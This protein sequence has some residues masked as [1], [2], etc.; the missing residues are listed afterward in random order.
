MPSLD[1]T[2]HPLIIDGIRIDSHQLRVLMAQLALPHLSSRVAA[3]VCP[4]REEPHFDVGS[5]AYTP[6]RVHECGC[7]GEF[8]PPG[9]IKN[10]IGNPM[11]ATLEKLEK[12]AARPRRIVTAGLS[13]EI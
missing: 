9:R 11:I 4:R 1:E 12:F 7:G 10:V 5:L 6:H 13:V 3:L 8:Q 2:Y